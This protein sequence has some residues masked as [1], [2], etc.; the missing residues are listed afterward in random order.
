MEKSNILEEP[1][2]E[3]KAVHKILTEEDKGE[4]AT[5]CTGQHAENCKNGDA[6]TGDL[7][8]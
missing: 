1:T 3:S 6:M 5:T 8:D 7:D 4:D 2:N